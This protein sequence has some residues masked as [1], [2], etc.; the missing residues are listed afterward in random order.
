MLDYLNTNNIPVS[1][2]GSFFPNTASFKLTDLSEDTQSFKDADLEKEEYIL[3]S[4]VFNQSDEII[5]NLFLSNNWTIE[6]II[7]KGSVYMILSRRK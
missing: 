3:F 5:D 6:K 7:K 1:S 4:N 2:V